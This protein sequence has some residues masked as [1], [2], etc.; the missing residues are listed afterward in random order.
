[1]GALVDQRRAVA[2]CLTL[3]LIVMAFAAFPAQ[4]RKSPGFATNFVAAYKTGYAR[5]ASPSGTPAAA[6]GGDREVRRKCPAA[7]AG[8]R[9]AQFDLGYLYAMGR[10]VRRNDALAAAWFKKAAAQGHPQARNWLALLRV[11]PRSEAE[12]ILSDGLPMGAKREFASNPAKGPIVDLVRNLAPEYKLDPNLVLAVVEAES[13]FN[14][15]ARSYRNAQGLMQLIP[16]TADRFGV[17][18]VWDPEQNLRGGMAYLRW[19]LD[20]FDGDVW[21]ALAGYNAGE[22]AVH[23]YN[24]V[25]PYDE[26]REYLSRI[27]GRLKH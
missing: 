13:N 6:D 2:R 1:M 22:E 23:R 16:A 9:N 14:P 10:G 4:A 3:V 27:A 25:P 17:E 5:P 18:D 20:H 7:Q 24:G 11:R 15:T 26:T 8:N 19:L 12:C 21:L